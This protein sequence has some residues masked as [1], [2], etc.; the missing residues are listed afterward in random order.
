MPNGTVETKNVIG[1]I[2]NVITLD[3]ALSATPNVNAIWLLQ[4]STLE[5][6]T[7]RVITVEEQDGINYAITAL[8]YIDGK[9]DNIESGISVPSRS[10]SLLN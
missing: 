7:F 1:I 3:S 10:I 6:Q 5:A 2:G 4:S 8:T 9:Y